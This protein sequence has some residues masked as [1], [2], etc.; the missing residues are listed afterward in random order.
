MVKQ[1]KM[2]NMC[3]EQGCDSQR[4]ELLSVTN[5]SNYR[6]DSVQVKI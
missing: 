1:A 2:I 4:A 6:A 3:L 5:L